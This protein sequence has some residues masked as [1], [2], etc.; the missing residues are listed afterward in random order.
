ME[1]LKTYEIYN[2]QLITEGLNLQPLLAK[3]KFSLNKRSIANLIVGSLLTILTTGQA[4][5]FIENHRGLDDDE[6][7]ALKE[8]V[9]KYSDPQI[10]KLSQEGWEHIK[11]IE[12]L[13]LKAYGIGDGMVTV[14][15]GHAQPIKK[16]RFKIGQTITEQEA[17]N[18]LIKDVN[19]AAEGV[20]RMFRQWKEDDGVDIKITQN[21]YDVL[22]SM[23]FNMGVS[24]LRKSQFIRTLKKNDLVKAAELIKRTGLKSGFG[25]IA[26]RRQLEYAKFIS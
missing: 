20:K 2:E 5:Q 26:T 9:S 12:V 10:L 23:A 24:G 22:V 13:K 19:V 1:Y 4:I 11:K 25:G 16:S 15:Y 18:Y 6:K 8:S 3:L 7:I 21:Q 17:I 14:G